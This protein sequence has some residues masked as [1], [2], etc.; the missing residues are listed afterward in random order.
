MSFAEKVRK[1]QSRVY[2]I[3]ST[4]DDSQASWF[5]LSLKPHMRKPFDRAIAGT[6]IFDLADY[7]EILHSG[8]GEQAAQSLKDKM[9]KEYGVQYDS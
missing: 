9:Q 8:Y 6:A 3:R 4:P 2:Y 7:G 5:F 1:Q